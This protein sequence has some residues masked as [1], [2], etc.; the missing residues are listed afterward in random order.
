MP[1]GKTMIS[2]KFS[3]SDGMK[4]G[5]I[6]FINEMKLEKS[7]TTKTFMNNVEF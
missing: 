6:I 1:K 7:L 5:T 4:C 3:S 2:R